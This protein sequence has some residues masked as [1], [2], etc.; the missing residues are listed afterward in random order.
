MT[1]IGGLLAIGEYALSMVRLSAV[2]ESY[3]RLG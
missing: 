2:H 1:V 3:C